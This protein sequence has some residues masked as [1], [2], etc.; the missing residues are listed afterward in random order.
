MIVCGLLFLSVVNRAY[1]APA[2]IPLSSAIHP[3]PSTFSA[4]TVGDFLNAC[5]SD[6]GGCADEVGAA[7]MD[8][9]TLD[10]TADIC[11]PSTD[12][13]VAVPEW[14]SSHPETHN[15]P[16]EDGIYLTVKTLYPCR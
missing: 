16:T 14:L 9:M 1:S 11:L 15:M 7:L 10:G 6:Q 3:A 4:P 2:E 8:K 13:A 12:Y 5:S